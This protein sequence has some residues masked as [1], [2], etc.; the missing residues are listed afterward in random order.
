VVVVLNN[1]PGSLEVNWGGLYGICGTPNGNKEDEYSLSTGTSLAYT[2]ASTTSWHNIVTEIRTWGMQLDSS[3]DPVSQAKVQAAINGATGT[4]YTVAAGTA[5]TVYSTAEVDGISTCSAAYWVVKAGFATPVEMCQNEAAPACAAEA[6]AGTPAYKQCMLDFYV[7]Y[8][9]AADHAAF[10]TDAKGWTDERLV[11]ASIYNSAI[12]VDESVMLGL[13]IGLGV[14]LVFVVAAVAFF[15][16]NPELLPFTHK[17]K[18]VMKELAA[19]D[20]LK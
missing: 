11:A 10:T 2:T 16:K 4:T 5:Q 7:A 19:T 13:F 1:P 14:G 6:A 18:K 8:K 3:Q 15:A 9:N 12:A 20:V 17:K